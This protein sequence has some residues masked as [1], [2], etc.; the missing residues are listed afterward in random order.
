MGKPVIVA[1][2]RSPIGRF[3]G[4][5]A[6]FSAPQL[7]ALAIKEALAR[8][9]VPADA[10]EEVI[11]GN[12]LSAGI[13]QAPARQAL[14]GAGIPDS[15]GALTIN[16]VCGSGLKAVMLA[17]QAIKA[18]DA[19]L[20]VAGGMESM[21]NVPYYLPQARGG[22]RL[23]HGKLLDGLI[24]DGLWDPYKDVHMGITGELVAEKYE[25]SR[26][27]QDAW[28]LQSHQRA[29][30]AETA[31]KFD[32][33]RFAIEQKDRKGNVTRIEKDE[34]PRGDTTLDGLAKLKPA[35]KQDGGTVTPG[36]ASTIN[37]GAAALVVMDADEAK[38]RGLRPLATITG[39]ATGG[40]APEW[41]M[42]APEIAV[43]K[44]CAITKLQPSQYDLVEL[45]EAFAVQTV[46]LNRV[47]DL[48]P[49]KVNV[50][51]G[52]VALGHPIGCS[53]ARILTTLLFA[54][55]DRK[56]SR[57]LASL[58]LG[59]GNAVAMAIEIEN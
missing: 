52:A 36:N 19:K 23:G 57:G 2:C 46:A 27:Q 58:C 49:A 3:Q 50:N 30:A 10:V 44:L 29:V 13:G 24:H 55:R 56:L 41:V 53:G 28:S 59:G 37:D 54:L 6:S 5:L 48:D 18:G 8:A 12:V 17:A 31:G 7:G 1:A 42:M 16:K 20:I 51:G 32:A 39:Y 9:Q 11:L 40:M 25:I 14:R 33:E 21:T 34:G 26:A 4:A 35:F 38:R 15:V 43:K 45:N 47:L 22:Q